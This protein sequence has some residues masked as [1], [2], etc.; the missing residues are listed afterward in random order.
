MMKVNCRHPS[1]YLPRWTND[2]DGKEFL[3]GLLLGRDAIWGPTHFRPEVP[4]HRDF[5]VFSLCVFQRFTLVLFSFF[6]YSFNSLNFLQQI[7]LVT[8]FRV[9]SGGT[10]WITLCVCWKTERTG[11]KHLH[12]AAMMKWWSSYFK[13]DL[14]YTFVLTSVPR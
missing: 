5:R 8:Q 4:L 2:D 14:W 10:Q 11:E 7:V 12:A 9:F 6:L 1:S 13:K 3:W